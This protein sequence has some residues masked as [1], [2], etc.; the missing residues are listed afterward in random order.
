MKSVMKHDFA[1][2]AKADIPRSSFNRSH[3]YKTAFDAG[4]LV[5][6]LLDE[7]LPGDTYNVRTSGFARMATPIYP[8]M[9]NLYA[10]TYYFAV[11]V[12]VLWENFEK[13]MGAQ[14]NPGDSTDYEV[15]QQLTGDGV[16]WAV[17]DVMDY[18][19]IRPGPTDQSVSALPFRAMAKIWNDWFRDENLDDSVT[20]VT[21]DGP[22]AYYAQPPL[23]CNKRHDYFTSALPWPQKGPEVN[24]PLGQTAPIIKEGDGTPVFRNDQT[25]QDVILRHDQVETAI[26]SDVGPASGNSENLRWLDP[27]LVTDLTNAESVSIN[28]MRQAF[29]VQKL[30]E[31]DARGGTRYQEIILSHFNVQGADARLQ[32]AEYL[33]GGKSPVH[34]H[35]VAATAQGGD[36]RPVGSTAAFGTLGIDGHGFTKSFTEHCII[37]GFIAVRADLTYSQGNNRLW[38]RK[39]KYDFYWPALSHLGEMPIYMKEL[40]STGTAGD[41]TVFGYTE[42]WN[43]YRFKPSLITGPMRTGIG[44]EGVGDAWTL[45]QYFESQPA[46]NSEFIT[47]NPPIDRVVA[48]P[49]EPH[50]IA[51]FYHRMICARPIPT[52]GTPGWIDRF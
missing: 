52:Y 12:R 19:G 25:G 5:P 33:G 49:D 17:G 6:F 41:D 24:L 13:F 42:R 44:A 48:T 26:Q 2:V 15:P 29:Q 11:P 10:Q 43:E 36:S 22:D 46:L 37:M 45:F 35:T 30:L 50:F 7:A 40:Y 32:R 9:D 1:R 28:T 4:R 34:I 18:L 38:Y 27:K 16:G 21:H 47:D 23:R 20:F 39:D 51:D 14:D 31:R 8:I 3:G